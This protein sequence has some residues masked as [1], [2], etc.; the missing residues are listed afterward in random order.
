M[1][2]PQ[3]AQTRMDEANR[4]RERAWLSIEAQ[5]RFGVTNQPSVSKESEP[6]EKVAG[7]G[8][9]I[10]Q[11]VFAHDHQLIG[12]ITRLFYAMKN[13]E[14]S[15]STSGS[16]TSGGPINGAQVSHLAVQ[17]RGWFGRH[18]VVPVDHV[19][20]VDG[21]GVLLAI[22]KDQFQALPNDRT[23]ANLGE[24]AGH[25]LWTDKVLRDMDYHQI[26]VH[27]NDGVV[28]LSGH[29]VNS[30]SQWRAEKAVEE[31][32]GV[33]RVR[34]HL[35]SDD[36]LIFEVEKALSPLDHTQRRQL[37]TKVENGV[38]ALFGEVSSPHVRDQAEQCIANL[39]W[40]RAV[41]ND[42]RITGTAQKVDYQRFL[43]RSSE[44]NFIFTVVLP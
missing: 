39:P 23:D 37:F 27:V 35:I 26:D 31:I 36:A 42:I 33:F 43:Q 12:L 15:G 5:R 32:P 6:S 20:Q 38:V 22:D 10:G 21:K 8:Y 19:R 29:V 17:T 41:L 13:A 40:V 24:D 11:E 34:N 4:C 18:K 3:T 16:S 2:E 28:V 14:N 7:G 1:F 25:A 30:M 44:K 9:N